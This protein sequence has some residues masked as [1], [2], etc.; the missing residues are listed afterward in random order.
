MTDEE[1]EDDGDE[2]ER[3][4]LLP[5]PDVQ[6]PSHGRGRHLKRKQIY[7]KQTKINK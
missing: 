2:D 4:L 6:L 3:R 7:S 1:D 5:P